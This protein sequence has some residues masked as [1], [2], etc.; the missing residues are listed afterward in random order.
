MVKLYV[1]AKGNKYT[2]TDHKERTI[3]NIKSGIGGKTY[4]INTGG[5]KLYYFVGDKKAK[6]P[7]FT[8]YRDNV[9][10]FTADCTSL[11]LDP[12]FEVRGGDISID[13]IS[14]DRLNFNIISKGNEIGT[15]TVTEQ[16]RPSEP[17]KDKKEVTET[18]YVIDIDEN[19]FDDYIPLLV[20]FIDLAFGELNKG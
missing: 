7:S 10:S 15:V 2:I 16:E 8:V 12:G 9:I 11:F 4:L 13:I 3:Y 6:K 20:V 14:H 19:Y 18:R 1:I 17:V 5:Y